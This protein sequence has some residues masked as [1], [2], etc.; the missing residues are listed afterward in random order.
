MRPLMCVNVSTSCEG[1]LP[2]SSLLEIYLQK[3]SIL[4]ISLRVSFWSSVRGEGAFTLSLVDVFVCSVGGVALA[5]LH[6]LL[7]VQVAGPSGVDVTN[8]WIKAVG[9]AVVFLTS[10][11]HDRQS[12]VLLQTPDIHSNVMLQVE[13]SRDHLFTLLLVFLQLRIS[14]KASGHCGQQCQIPVDSSSTLSQ[15]SKCH[16]LPAL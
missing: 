12:A 9:V 8:M 10:T 2:L 16:R 15:H 4:C 3:G 11:S 13:S 5:M 14:V 7:Q 1:A 6:V